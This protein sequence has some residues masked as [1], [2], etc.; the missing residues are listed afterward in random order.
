MALA[1]TSRTTGRSHTLN[2]TLS[3]PEL[4]ASVMDWQRF[5]T[6]V[7]T[8]AIALPWLSY[9]FEVVMLTPCKI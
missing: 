6:K 1:K 2:K 7:F 8:S 3:M 9:N 4:Q 5:H